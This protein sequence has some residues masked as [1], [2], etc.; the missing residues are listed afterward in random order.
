MNGCRVSGLEGRLVEVQHL[1]HRVDPRERER[2]RERER[3]GGR[4]EGRGRWRERE[5][6]ARAR[7]LA[8]D[9]CA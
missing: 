9:E 5:S 4:E 1:R 3:R 2:E 6:N 7:R 8:R